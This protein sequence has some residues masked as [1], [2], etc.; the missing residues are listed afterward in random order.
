MK[1]TAAK[2][3]TL[4]RAG[5]RL[6]VEPVE[7][8]LGYLA[9]LFVDG[10]LK[11]EQKARD[12]RAQL[13][14]GD[15]TVRVRWG[16]FGQVTQCVLVE[17]RACDEGQPVQELPFEPPPGTRAARLARLERE[18]P[19]LYASR[20]VLWAVL[21]LLLPLLGIGALLATLLP[22]IDLTW[23]PKPLYDELFGGSPAWLAPVLDSPIFQ[24]AKWSLPILLAIAVA[25]NEVKKRGAKTASADEAVST[26]GAH[27]SQGAVE[28]TRGT[29]G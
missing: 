2:R 26:D 14:A 17:N 3:Y 24:V 10:E 11:A 19:V 16:S 22:H 5:H 7:V 6:E 20:H 13:Q 21:H 29:H 1:A 12:E 4:E 18:R 28:E 25:V 27:T 9:R 23:L 15:F 8:G